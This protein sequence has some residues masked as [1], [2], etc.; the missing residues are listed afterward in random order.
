MQ[1]LK[2]DVH[3]DAI[4]ILTV[5]FPILRSEP[6]IS[7]NK[8]SSFLSN[9]LI[10]SSFLW[11]PHTC[12]YGTACAIFWSHPPAVTVRNDRPCQK[13]KS[14]LWLLARL[15]PCNIILW[16]WYV[17]LPSPSTLHD[18]APSTFTCDISLQKN[19]PFSGKKCAYDL[20]SFVSD[21]IMWNEKGGK[22][23][24]NVVPTVPKISSRCSRF[25]CYFGFPLKPWNG[26]KT[27]KAHLECFDGILSLAGLPLSTV[28]I[29]KIRHWNDIQ[30]SRVLKYRLRLLIFHFNRL[31]DSQTQMFRK[32]KKRKEK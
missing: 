27:L 22:S 20:D 6:Q 11:V 24:W 31:T 23:S 29:G 30:E 8:V 17:R 5:S 9:F 16:P 13:I 19:R 25:S 18:L 4:S 10:Q 32:R 26:R 12:C 7:F 14:R 21:P 1:L 15:P 28:E 3:F 2:F